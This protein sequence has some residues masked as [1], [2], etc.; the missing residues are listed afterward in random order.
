M[1]IEYSF[2]G[3]ISIQLEPSDLRSMQDSGFTVDRDG[4]S[5]MDSKTWVHLAPLDVDNP[6]N[7]N[8]NK[9]IIEPGGD[10]HVYLARGS[11]YRNTTEIEQSRIDAP[12]GVVEHYLAD[13]SIEIRWR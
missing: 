2:P 11:G 6:S 1:E 8:D 10:L 3:P 9:A 12:D 13:G 5:G 7:P 4:F